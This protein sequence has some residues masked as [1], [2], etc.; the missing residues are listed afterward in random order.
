MLGCRLWKLVHAFRSLETGVVHTDIRLAEVEH[1][2]EVPKLVKSVSFMEERKQRVYT[3]M[4]ECSLQG[5]YWSM[6]FFLWRPVLGILRIGSTISTA[7][8]LWIW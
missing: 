5:E 2:E 3:N 8:D 1:V 7:Q 6:P 4:S